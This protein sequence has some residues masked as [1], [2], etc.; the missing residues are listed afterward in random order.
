MIHLHKV[1]YKSLASVATTHPN[2]WNIQARKGQKIES[3]EFTQWQVKGIE[4]N[5]EVNVSCPTISDLHDLC[6]QGAEMS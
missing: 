3:L 5:Q 4:S 2:I 6:W 1:L